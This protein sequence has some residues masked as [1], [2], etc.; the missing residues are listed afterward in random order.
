MTSTSGGLVK[1]SMAFDPDVLDWLRARGQ[2]ID[3]K[4]SWQVREILRAAMDDD[5]RQ[6]AAEQDAAAMRQ[7]M[8]EEGPHAGDGAGREGGGVMPKFRKKPVVIEAMLV[9]S[10]QDGDDLTAW[11]RLGVWLGTGRKDGRHWDVNT[12]GGVD[13][14]TL[15]GTMTAQP[16]DWI[17]RGVKGEF[18]PCKPDIFAAT[19]EPVE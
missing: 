18:Y 19:Y 1:L 4:V 12:D 9:P 7:Q 14:I 15:E 10:T 13:I 11:G 6:Q 3:R 17:I 2:R 5:L 16:G 8:T